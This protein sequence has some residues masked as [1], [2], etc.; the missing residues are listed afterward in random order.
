MPVNYFSKTQVI[1]ELASLLNNRG[2]IYSKPFNDI[3]LQHDLALVLG[4]PSKVPT[5]LLPSGYKPPVQA[6]EGYE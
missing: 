2:R 3:E 4:I 1:K 6:K 5:V